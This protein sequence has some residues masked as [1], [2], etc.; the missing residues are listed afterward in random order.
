LSNVVLS[1]EADFGILI[2]NTGI[3][4][5]MCANRFKGIRAALCLFPQMA[6]AARHHND[7]NVLVLGACNTAFSL[8]R[9]IVNVFIEESFDGSRHKRRINKM[10]ELN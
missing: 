1:G 6:F 7:A 5:S 8:A 4:M 10:D 3:G 9:E 2:C